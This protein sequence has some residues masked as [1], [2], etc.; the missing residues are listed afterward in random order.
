MA[1]IAVRELSGGKTGFRGTGARNTLMTWPIWSRPL[2]V[3]TLRTVL[4]LAELQA[5]DRTMNR[6]NI[7]QKLRSRGI[8]EIYRSQRLTIGKFRNFAFARSV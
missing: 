2:T 5:D 1:L 3:D 4:G 8:V 7:R 6:E